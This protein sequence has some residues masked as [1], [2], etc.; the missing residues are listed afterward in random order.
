[1][2]RILILCILYFFFIIRISAQTSFCPNLDFE[3]GT[4]ANWSGFIGYC[5]PINTSGSGF[6]T[7]RHT[8]TSG[9]GF[10]PRTNNQIPVVAPDGGKHSVRLGNDNVNKEAE[11]LKYTVAV[12]NASDLFIYRYAVVLEDPEHPPEDQPRF[13]IRVYDQLGQNIQCGIYNVVASAN[14]PGFQNYNSIRFKTWT[15]VGIDLSGYIGQNIIVEFRTGDC[16]QGAHFGYAYIDCYCGPLE[17]Q[18]AF[19]PNSINMTLKAPEGFSS[20]IWS[21]GATTSSIIVT[22]ADIGNIYSCTLTSVTGCT[23]TLTSSVASASISAD[24]SVLNQC[25][26]NVVF[27]DQTTALNGYPIKWIWNFGDGETSLSQSPIHLY[28]TPGTYSI[29]LIT[30]SSKGCIDSAISQLL[31]WPAPQA[32]ASA[33]NACEES[34]V[35]FSDSSNIVFGNIASWQW[36]F[37]NGSSSTL[38]SPAYLFNGPGNYSANLIV[39]SDLGCVDTTDLNFNVYSNPV[40][41]AGSDVSFCGSRIVDLGDPANPTL[42][43]QWSPLN[44]ILNA[45]SQMTKV[46]IPEAYQGLKYYQYFLTGRNAVTGC[47][48]IDSILIV[49]RAI[50]KAAFQTPNAQCFNGNSFDLTAYITHPGT[51]YQWYFGTLAQPVYVSNSF[52][53]G[54]HYLQPGIFPLKLVV[55]NNGCS[56]SA[57]GLIKVV[58]EPVIQFEIEEEGCVPLAVNFKSTVTPAGPLTYQWSFSNNAYSTEENPDYLYTSSGIYSVSLKVTDPYGCSDYIKLNNVIKVLPRPEAN[59][60]SEPIAASITDPHFSFMNFS[61]NGYLLN[62]DFGDNSLSYDFNSFHTYQDTGHY[63]IRLIMQNSLGC[64]DTSFAKVIVEPYFS[65]YIPNSFTPNDD[66]VNDCFRGIGMYI[67]TYEMWIY[68]RL[69]KMIY[70]TSDYALPWKG[71][72]PNEIVAQNDVYEYIIKI[73]DTNNQTHDYKGHVTLAH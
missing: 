34:P 66:G 38:A 12:T 58:E 30:E 41:E 46:N 45:D 11:M 13:E 3:T 56:D 4:L 52:A 61:Q 67:K 54:I 49:T 57:I 7:E 50:P 70:F 69:G 24:F 42:I 73:T 6:V 68:N 63:I 51:I 53:T 10:D 18:N 20:Y 15:T 31:I 62:W 28:Q 26:N 59:F 43:Y 33:K 14:I 9:T 37:S 1:M 23:V 72:Y 17:I 27:N 65:F 29:Q 5:C 60:V 21:N 36:S 32:R 71:K 25:Q 2:I 19:C 48:S 39:T 16:A 55:N 35:L 22:S 8:I 64:N 44:G 47:E 40:F